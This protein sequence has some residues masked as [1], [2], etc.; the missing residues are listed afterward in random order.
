MT[1]GQHRP[2]VVTAIRDVREHCVPTP[3]PINAPAATSEHE[4]EVESASPAYEAGVL[5][6]EPF[7][8]AQAMKESNPPETG[9]GDQSAPGA[10]P[11]CRRYL[12][13]EEGREAFR[14]P[15][16]EVGPFRETRVWVAGARSYPG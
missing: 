2:R 13:N 3:R 9:F 16:L 11:M 1:R 6:A 14:H 8:L 10:W 7:V 4:A 12:Q 15:A 5:P